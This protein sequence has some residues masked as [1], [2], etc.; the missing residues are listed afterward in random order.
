MTR[1]METEADTTRHGVRGYAMQERRRLIRSLVES[2]AQCSVADL[3]RRFDVSAVTIRSDLAALAD[4]GALVRI[5]G[6]AL[7]PGEGEEVPIN[8]KQTLYHAEKVR[9]AAEAAELIQ[10]G[11]TVI[12]D[13][14]TTTAEIARQLR[15]LKLRSIN[16]IT[17]ALNIAVL[18]ANAH[19]VN[20]IIPGGVLR[21]KSWSLSGPQAEAAL[22]DLQADRLFIGVDSLDPDIGLMTPHVLEA[23]LNALMIR[24]AR[25]TV[26]VTDSSK[27][28][29]RNLSVIAPVE[30]VHLLITDRAAPP[31]AVAAIRARGVEV[32][33]V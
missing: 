18:L 6:G 26:A 4:S 33:L 28:L 9:I 8:I 3:A 20:L 13:S 30:Q 15:S 14:G 10:D 27:L 19:H 24:I 23:K 31:E 11:E 2:Q 29:R 5:H 25:Q 17:N 7:P 12:L 22:R 21:R 16:V 1:E 32:R